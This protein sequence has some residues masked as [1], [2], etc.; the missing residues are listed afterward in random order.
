[1]KGRIELP[2]PGESSGCAKVAGLFVLAFLALVVPAV[3]IT[4]AIVA[5][6]VPA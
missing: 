5:G 6:R 3:L 1:M 2:A 4:V